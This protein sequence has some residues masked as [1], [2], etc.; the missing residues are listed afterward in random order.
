[1]DNPVEKSNQEE[2]LSEEILL[3]AWKHCAPAATTEGGFPRGFWP[4]VARV[5]VEIAIQGTTEPELDF[6]PTCCDI[7]KPSVVTGNRHDRRSRPVNQPSVLWRAG[8]NKRLSELR[9]E[10]T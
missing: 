2:I 10:L 8:I 1:M 9:R 6:R 4:D 7:G 3:A 5:A